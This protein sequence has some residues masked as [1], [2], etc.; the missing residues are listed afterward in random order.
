MSSQEKLKRVYDEV[1]GYIELDSL[2]QKIVS[3]PIFQRLRRI[4]Q[5]GVAEYV[6]P[7]AT[8]NR[9]SHSLG[10]YHLMKNIIYRLRDYIDPDKVN[11]LLAAALLHDVGHLPYSHAL[12]TYYMN[13]LG[14]VTKIDHEYLSSIVIREDPD[15]KDLLKS[16]GIEPSEISDIINSRHK[17]PLYNSLLSSDLDV[18]RMDYLIRDSLHTGVIYGSIDLR[19]ILS[20][21]EIDGRR[22]IGVNEKGLIAVENFYLARLH[23]YRAVY[24]HKT[25]HG[26]ELMLVRLWE[27]MLRE[28][29][30]L[31]VYRDF[32]F[33]RKM[34]SEGLYRYFDDSVIVS[35]ISSVA[36]D[37]YLRREIREIAEMFL[38]RR[39]YK[40]IYDKIILSEEPMTN[41]ENESEEIKM[42]KEV[43]YFMDKYGIDSLYYIPVI[44][45]IAIYRED[46][47]ITIKSKDGSERKIF[48]HEGSIIK[49]LPKYMN[50][51]RFYVHPMTLKISPASDIINKY[52]SKRF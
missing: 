17:D 40:V 25:V 8:H 3:L 48:E 30:D 12:E 42:I 5:L 16:E 11:I 41:S 43:I 45:N 20:T 50:I 39:G 38:F 33:I 1:H 23:M 36:N 2:A 13:I 27:R 22:R 46:E 6:Y 34:I 19:R 10:V 14:P 47:A 18:D 4:K 24:Y 26:Y 21:L 29:T 44:E 37:Q 49:D 31:A 52:F 15:L 28:R 32:N 35:Y 9:F 51:L 7:G